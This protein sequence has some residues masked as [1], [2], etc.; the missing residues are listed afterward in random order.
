MGKSFTVEASARVDAPAGLVYNIIADYRN[1]HPHFLPKQ[2][3]EWLEVEQGGRGAGTVIRF[4]MRVLGQTRV[5]RAAV[6]EPEPGRVL[7]ETDTGGDGPVTTFVVEPEGAGS[8]V[9][10]STEMTSAGGPFGVLERFVL[11]RVLRRV[12]AAELK[13]LGQVAVERT[14]VQTVACWASF[15]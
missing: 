1:G 12:Y 10:F 15:A 9:T 2:Y 5:M 11:R 6:T 13:Q 3:F 4:Q 8:R 7:V 14:S